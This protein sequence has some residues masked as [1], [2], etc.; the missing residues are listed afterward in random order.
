MKLIYTNK[1][2]YIKIAVD[3]FAKVGLIKKFNLYFFG[4]NV[5][6][7]NLLI[8]HMKRPFYLTLFLILNTFV[9]ISQSDSKN[10]YLVSDKGCKM[11]CKDCEGSFTWSGKCL[12]GYINGY[13]SATSI[14]G[15][16]NTGTFVQGEISGQGTTI[17]PNDVDY[18]FIG[19][20]KINRR[21]NGK[22]YYKDGEVYST[23]LEGKETLSRI[24]QLERQISDQAKKKPC[25]VK[26]VCYDENPSN[27]DKI[28]PSA[29][30]LV[31]N[32]NG[33]KTAKLTLSTYN[34]IVSAKEDDAICNHNS[35]YDYKEKVFHYRFERSKR[36]PSREDMREYATSI[37]SESYNTKSGCPNGFNFQN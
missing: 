32:Y 11:V 3:I 10:N 33:N 13:G 34:G 19:T 37:L 8:F 31:E 22:M 24:A 29:V 5:L 25:I 35:Y 27:W 9:A 20:Y 21:W 28:G 26:F 14:D 30:F 23:I 6:K 12:N 16:I 36:Y 7:F 15:T 17:W 2:D 18:K 1:L 4:R